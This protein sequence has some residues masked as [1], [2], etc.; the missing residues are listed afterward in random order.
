[1]NVPYSLIVMAV[2]GAL[3]I[4]AIVLTYNKIDDRAIYRHWDIN[5]PMSLVDIVRYDMLRTLLFFWVAIAIL[6]LGMT[7][8][9]VEKDVVQGVILMIFYIVVLVL[10]LKIV[11]I[12]KRTEMRERHFLILR[13]VSL[14]EDKTDLFRF[15]FI[16][17]SKQLSSFSTEH[18]GETPNDLA[19][20]F[21]VSVQLRYQDSE[22]FQSRYLLE[23]TEQSYGRL[24]ELAEKGEDIDAI[25]QF[26]LLPIIF[27]KDQQSLV[28]S[29]LVKHASDIAS[30]IGE[31]ASNQLPT[32]IQQAEYPTGASILLTLEALELQKLKRS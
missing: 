30:T 3:A 9:V 16:Q 29:L 10:C 11:S 4:A 1:M 8:L 20:I 24:K 6:A 32:R 12:Q 7:Y 21:K 5:R 15:L 18:L 19:E 14:M 22:H 27:G 2:A 23:M 17:R 13:D 26:V 31:H 25:V 28:A